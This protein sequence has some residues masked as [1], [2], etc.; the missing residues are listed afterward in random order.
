M[1][2]I[3]LALT[4]LVPAISWADDSELI[5]AT[6]RCDRALR[7]IATQLP[8]PLNEVDLVNLTAKERTDKLAAHQADY[9]KVQMGRFEA[10]NHLD[11]TQDLSVQMMLLMLGEDVVYVLDGLAL[12]TGAVFNREEA[13]R[14]ASSFKPVQTVIGGANLLFFGVFV[15]FVGLKLAMHGYRWQKGDFEQDLKSIINQDV[16][17]IGVNAILLMPVMSLSVIQIF[18]VATLCITVHLGKPVVNV[19]FA[20]NLKENVIEEM[21]ERYTPRYTNMI[22]QNAMIYICDM[23]RRDT[24]IEQIVQEKGSNVKSDLESDSLYKC[25]TSEASES[26][27]DAQYLSGSSFGGL[28][29]GISTQKK[30]FVP[31]LARQ[32]EQCFDSHKDKLPYSR[33][34]EIGDCGDVTIRVPVQ[35]SK[36]AQGNALV[37]LMAKVYMAPSM[38]AIIEDLAYLEY[39]RACQRSNVLGTRLQHSNMEEMTCLKRSGSQMSYVVDP[40]TEQE[41]IA[42]IT[43]PLTASEESRIDRKVEVLS[44]QVAGYLKGK[45]FDMVDIINKGTADSETP[46]LNEVVSDRDL[47]RL[48]QQMER[49]QWLAAGLFV[50]NIQGSQGESVLKDHVNNS[51]SA[52]GNVMGFSSEIFMRDPSG[53]ISDFM[54]ASYELFSDMIVPSPKLYDTQVECWRASEYCHPV[55]TNPFS[56]MNKVGAEH[57]FNSSIPYAITSFLTSKKVGLHKSIIVSTLDK[58]YFL[59]FMLG[60]L[61]AVIIPLIPVMYI[62]GA[63]ASWAQDVLRTVILLQINLCA[64]PLGALDN[65]LFSQEVRQS[66][67]QLIILAIYL[68]F[69]LL[70]IMMCFL[71]VSFF[72]ALNV[73]VIG[74]FMS[75]VGLEGNEGLVHSSVMQV[76][77]DTLTVIVLFLEVKFASEFIKKVPEALAMHFNI[78]IARGGNFAEEMVGKLKGQVLP[79]ISTFVSNVKM[80]SK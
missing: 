12:A 38:Q 64:S 78:Q 67:A 73:I 48:R 43:M 68:F 32:T 46:A 15:F 72:F 39:Q 51:Y 35:K 71:V 59:E 45:T 10:C 49:G 47:L 30:V 63:M 57:I 80:M 1:I 36:S 34:D 19:F 52:S 76:V 6:D 42:L 79:E 60:I 9:M 29:G 55:P 5:Q 54:N 37:D 69:I 41:R 21:Q 77:Y 66:F 50:S 62:F 17:S 74:V 33:F 14:I 4:L 2:R 58:V 8:Q 44:R 16:S 75:L 24:L 25:L 31:A 53:A 70:G 11:M 13:M 28:S 23:D 26:L 18:L 20:A 56:Y 22:S 3:L 65:R 7:E 27:V 40:L 61:L